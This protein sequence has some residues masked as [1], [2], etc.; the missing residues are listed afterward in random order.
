MTEIVI[1]GI[2]T[3]GEIHKYL[4]EAIIVIP[5]YCLD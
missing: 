5:L 2:V 4:A 3:L 1:W